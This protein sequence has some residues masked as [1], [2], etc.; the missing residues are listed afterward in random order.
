MREISTTYL[1]VMRGTEQN[2]FGDDTDVGVPLYRHVPA[3][4]VEVSHQTFDRAEGTQRTIRT[5]RCAVPSWA[6][7]DTDDTIQDELTGQFYMIEDI[8]RQP[9]LGLP[10]DTLL[11]L[12]S[13]SGISISTD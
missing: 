9:T 7:I 4:I 10:A 6:D 5:I 2:K 11:T 3:S 1:T 12:Q 8:Q 13:R